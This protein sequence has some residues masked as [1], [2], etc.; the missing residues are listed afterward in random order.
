MLA[1][2]H[3]D[4]ADVLIRLRRPSEAQPLLERALAN[5]Q[6]FATPEALGAA[7]SRLAFAASANND[8]QSTLR[9][10]DMRAR[11]LPPTP[12]S[13]F[14]AATAHD[15]L[16]HVKEASNLY[17]QFLAEAKGQFPDEE[18]EAKHR[19]LALEHTK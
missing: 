19:L 5:P 3:G 16:H 18:W 10:L 4:R 11:V 1:S 14:L 9:A 2:R 12:S 13:T 8:P 6:A 7:A 17:K 15:K